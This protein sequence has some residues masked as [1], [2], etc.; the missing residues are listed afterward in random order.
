M[1]IKPRPYQE[2]GAK[3]V[4]RVL[5]KYAISYIAWEERTGKSLTG[6]LA[7]ELHICTTDRRFS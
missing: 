5:K 2:E 1:R 3:E 6:V 7:V 4:L